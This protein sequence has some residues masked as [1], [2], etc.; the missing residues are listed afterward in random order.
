[1]TFLKKSDEH[2]FL[3]TSGKNGKILVPLIHE[4]PA[5]IGI[6]IFCEHPEYHKEWS[7]KFK[8]VGGNPA[9][10]KKWKGKKM[11]RKIFIFFRFPLFSRKK[12][13]FF[14]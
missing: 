9:T 13:I 10:E 8:K 6:V 3:V 5:I 11:E 14:P 7:S 2:W 12:N 4:E 1:M